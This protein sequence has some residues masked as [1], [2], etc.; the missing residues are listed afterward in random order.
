MAIASSP[1]T[2]RV[3][4]DPLCPGRISGMQCGQFIEYLCNLVPGMWSERLYDGNFEGLSPYKFDFIAQSDFKEKP[5]VPCGAVNRAD[6]S[7]DTK[8]PVNGQTCQKIAVEGGTPCTVGISQEGLFLDPGDPCRLSVWLKQDGIA[9]P[10]KVR[11]SERGTPLASCEFNPGHAWK[12]Y[13]ATISPSARSTEATIRIEF[14]GPG[15]LWVDAASLMPIRTVGGWRPDVVK[16]LKEL[17]PGVIRIGGSV[18]DDPNLGSFEWK[19]T[20]GDP[21]RRTPF[22]AWGGL[23]PT[24]PGLEEF[25]Q[26]CRA[27]DAEPLI[28]VRTR[29]KTPKDAAE[30]VEYFNGAVSTPMGALRA[31]NGHPEPYHVKYW[32]VGNER[33]GGEYEAQLPEFC[34][35]MKAVDP[36]ISLMSSFP[37]EGVLRGSGGLLDYVCPHHYDCENL[38]AENEDFQNI[39]QMIAAFAPGRPIKVGVTEW[40]TTAG[41]RGLKR[42]RLW[43]LENALACSRYQNLMHR[44]C[45]LVEIANRSNL[46]NSFCSGILQTDSARLYLT[47][48]YYAQK[49]YAN[50]AGTRPLKIDPPPPLTEGLDISATLS[51]SD[52]TLTLFVVNESMETVSRHFDL[53]GDWKDAEVWTLADT[54]KADEPDAT[55]SFDDPRRIVPASSRAKVGGSVMDYQFS[56]LSLTVLVL[57]R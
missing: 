47:P 6:F 36:T 5:W 56:P 48:T 37:T 20:I 33:W 9:G 51:E 12:R 27:V 54:K 30:E 57:R 41:D 29:A 7:L 53:P 3:T 50:Y 28:C 14:R 19:D 35:A 2:V 55:N 17:K 1:D 11:F 32:Q 24:G 34:K 4:L 42:A 13:E 10:V 38:A 46:T 31:K 39:R 25:V 40:N 16:A 49:L 8:D 44:N 23:Q 21:D 52:D 43:T 15:T 18:M 45:D 26:L 22:R